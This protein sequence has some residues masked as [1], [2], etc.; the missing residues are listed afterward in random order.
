MLIVEDEEIIRD[1]LQRTLQRRGVEVLA[2]NGGR[3]GLD[4]FRRHHD[5]ISLVMTDFQR[6]GLDGL[7]V[8]REIRSVSA[9]LPV[10]VMSG[11][12]DDTTLMALR[13]EG[14][15]GLVDKPF[16]YDQVLAAV[17]SSLG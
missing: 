8:L 14:V 10:L 4:L 16:G 2:A 1:V 13:G 17:R 7:A 3:E 6:P 15:S 5:R 12:I 9:T 11:R